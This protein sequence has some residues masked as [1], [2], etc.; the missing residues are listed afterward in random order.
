MKRKDPPMI[1]TWMLEH[2]TL[3]GK[4]EALACDLLEEFRHGR[5]VTWYW[6]QVLMA[7][8]VEFAG[9][10]RTRWPAIVYATLWAIPGPAYLIL[11]VRKIVDIPFFA[12]RWQLEWPYSTI[13]DQILFWGPQLIYIWS[14]LIVYF[15][16]LSLATRTVNIHRLGQSLW[17]SPLVFMAVCVALAAFF[18]LLPGHAGHAIDVR[19]VTG[20]HL[21]TDFLFLE[22][23]PVFFFTIFL[24]IWMTL[25]RMDKRL[26]RVVC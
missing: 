26:T 7:I 25:S 10:L 4:N 24:S 15:L 21:I 9:E 2:L 20:L 22:L 18:A 6:R 8:V 14:A 16:L 19:H 11:A 5:P 12:R 3:G 1:A 13:C 23:R 17:K